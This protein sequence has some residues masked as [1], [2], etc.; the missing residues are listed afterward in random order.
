MLRVVACCWELL[1][2][3]KLFESTIPNISIVQ[4]IAERSTTMID[5]LAQLSPTFLGPRTPIAHCLL[6]DSNAI[7]SC[8]TPTSQHWANIVG[9]SVC[10]SQPRRTKPLPTLLAQ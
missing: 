3:D 4:G 6:G 9:R 1:L 7:T 10:T 5:P 8:D 2:K